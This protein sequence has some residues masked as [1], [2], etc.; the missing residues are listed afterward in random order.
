[1]GIALVTVCI[2][3]LAVV[4]ADDFTGIGVADDFLYGPLGTGVGK[5]IIMIFG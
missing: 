4:I 3:G 2:I 5:G 1:M